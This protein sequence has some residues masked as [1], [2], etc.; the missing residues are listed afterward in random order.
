[1]VKY[2]KITGAD[3]QKVRDSRIKITKENLFRPVKLLNITDGQTIDQQNLNIIA[4]GHPNCRYELKYKNVSYPAVAKN[5]GKLKFKVIPL[6][7]G[8]N[9]F[10]IIN[11]SHRNIKNQNL[12]FQ[13][14]FEVRQKIY[15][16]YCD[17]LTGK[18]FSLDDDISDILRCKNCG[19]FY[20]LFTINECGNICSTCQHSQFWNHQNKEFYDSRKP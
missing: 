10:E 12:K 11:P 6:E 2:Y 19:T 3:I 14:I 4:I 9:Y 17:P 7:K 5:D 1:M 8:K 20:Y 18:Q 13:V 15:L 16:K